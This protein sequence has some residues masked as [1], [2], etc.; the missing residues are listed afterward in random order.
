MRGDLSGGWEFESESERWARWDEVHEEILRLAH[1]LMQECEDSVETHSL[2]SRLEQL[3]EEA[4][5]LRR[6]SV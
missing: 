1:R 2:V 6:C 5:R 4:E 3:L